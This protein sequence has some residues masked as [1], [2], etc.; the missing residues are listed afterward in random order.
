MVVSVSLPLSH[1]F[2]SSVLRFFELSSVKAT[3]SSFTAEA[4]F[5]VCS[6]T[7]NSSRHASVSPSKFYSVFWRMFFPLSSYRYHRSSSFSLLS[8]VHRCSSLFSLLRALVNSVHVHWQ[9]HKSRDRYFSKVRSRRT[10]YTVERER[11]TQ[12]CELCSSSIE[13]STLCLRTRRVTTM[14]PSIHSI[15]DEMSEKRDGWTD[16]PKVF[17]EQFS[18]FRTGGGVGINTIKTM[19]REREMSRCLFFLLFLQKS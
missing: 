19:R 17:S 14:I 7:V 10:W 6:K 8:V 12:F 1:R 16:T 9:T 18:N 5:E 13:S 11:D 4:I 2:H 15:E 3:I